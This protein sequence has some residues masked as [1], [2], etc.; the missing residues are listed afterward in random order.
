MLFL[1]FVLKIIYFESL[2]YERM[3]CYIP[4]DIELDTILTIIKKMSINISIHVN[5]YAHHVFILKQ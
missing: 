5:E 1:I 3:F 4:V 2:N